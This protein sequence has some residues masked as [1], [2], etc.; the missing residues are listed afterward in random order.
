MEIKCH[1]CGQTFDGDTTELFHSAYCKAQVSE[2]VADH[3]ITTLSDRSL[4]VLVRKYK[5]ARVI[6]RK[7]DGEV[8]RKEWIS[9]EVADHVSTISDRALWRLVTRYKLLGL[10]RRKYDI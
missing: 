1:F 2:V 5:L 8:Y 4:W 7:Y 3:I 9:R 10:V 6:K